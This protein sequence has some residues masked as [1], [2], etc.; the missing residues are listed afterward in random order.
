MVFAFVLFMIA[1]H[2]FEKMSGLDRL[3]D[4]Y[5]RKPITEKKVYEQVQKIWA[6]AWKNDSA[7]DYLANERDMVAVSIQIENKYNLKT[8]IKPMYVR[9]FLALTDLVDYYK[10]KDPLL[11]V[12]YCSWI[13][14]SRNP[15]NPEIDPTGKYFSQQAMI[16][17]NLLAKKNA[18]DISFI[19]RRVAYCLACS[20]YP[21]A[22]KDVWEIIVSSPDKTMLPIKEMAV[23]YWKSRNELTNEQV[24][25]ILA[26]SEKS[27]KETEMDYILLIAKDKEYTRSEIARRGL[28]LSDSKLKDIENSIEEL[29]KMNYTFNEFGE[30]E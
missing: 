28:K 14:A 18:T 2:G 3:R 19:G 12:D 26:N 29:I 17:F 11:A 21:N 7:M 8:L 23:V 16:I 10:E 27:M 4:F 5:K 20:T 13:I 15:S 24:D 22:E 9:S 25:I 1:S 30:H 6:D